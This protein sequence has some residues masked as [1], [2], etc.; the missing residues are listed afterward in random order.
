MIV[1]GPANSSDNDF[2]RTESGIFGSSDL[3]NLVYSIPKSDAYNMRYM[4][5][6]DDGSG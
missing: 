4:C 3:S 6:L 2:L 5:V 1:A